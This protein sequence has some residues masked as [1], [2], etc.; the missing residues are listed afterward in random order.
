MNRTK[1]EAKEKNSQNSFHF[2]LGILWIG[3]AILIHAYLTYV[4]FGQL[5]NSFSQSICDLNSL[6]N[7]SSVATSK[8]S[9]FLGIPVSL[10]GLMTN[11]LLMIF[12]VNAKPET[13][14]HF[15]RYTLWLAFLIPAGSLA[16]GVISLTKMSQYCPFCIILYVLSFLTL[17]NVWSYYKTPFLK[18]LP[19]DLL[20]LFTERMGMLAVFF[21]IPIGAWLINEI[22]LDRFQKALGGHDVELLIQQRIGEWKANSVMKI[23]TAGAIMLNKGTSTH[24]MIEFADFMCHH[25]QD[26]SP[27]F[28]GFMK[29][30]PEI[31]F[32][33]MP[34]PLDGECN[35]DIPR[36]WGVSCRFSKAAYCANLQNQGVESHHWLFKNVVGTTT[37]NE[38]D[39]L[40]TKMASELKLD[41][42]QFEEC[43]RS[44]RT[45]K[46]IQ[47]LAK[48]GVK[49]QI[50][51][52][53]TVFLN[54]RQLPGAQSA[55]ILKAAIQHL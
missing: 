19:Q 25:C 2:R 43:T 35:D 7:C 26:A 22:I 18:D 8:Y 30:H 5:S 20:A 9:K 41:E 14:A 23:N 31:T 32:I 42:K 21:L 17:W 47:D 12:F 16:M 1:S 15:V 28:D 38:A 13:S 44:E 29:A 49:A 6:F 36:K 4:H 3:A 33:Y 55:A 37:T 27:I 52:T 40:I 45:H 53:P 48:E 24:E 51:G 34:F 39:T 46:A 10:W 50:G 11:M 54:G